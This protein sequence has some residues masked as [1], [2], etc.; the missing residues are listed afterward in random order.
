MTN[1]E[2][3]KAHNEPRK[4]R[5]IRRTP[6]VDRGWVHLKLGEMYYHGTDVEPDHQKALKYFQSAAEKGYSEATRYIEL[7]TKDGTLDS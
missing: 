2:Y 5:I 7:L 3:Q 1:I 6:R 4:R